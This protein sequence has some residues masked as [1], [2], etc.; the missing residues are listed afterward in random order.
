MEI[1]AAHIAQL[2]G[3]T[4]HGDPAT[5]IR[6]VNGIQE[7]AEG[8]L[9]FVRSP[10]YAALLSAS[11]ASAV[12]IAEPIEELSL[13]QLVTPQP[14]LAFAQ[15]LQQF[16]TDQT[17]HPEGIHPTAVVAE[18]ARLGKGVALD[19]HVVVAEGAVLGDRV[20]IYAGAYIGRNVNIG[21]ET[22]VY[23][24]AVIREECTIGARC[25]LH[26][27]CT[28][29]T[30]G[31]G[32][33]PLGGVWVKIPQVGRVVVGD[34]VEVG[35][36]TAIDRATFGETR[37]GQ[38]TKIDNLVQIGHNVRIGEHCVIAGMAG[39]AGSAVIGNN[40]RVGASAGINGHIDIGDGASIGA[41]AGVTHSVPAGATVSGFPAIDHN[42]QRR[43]LVAQQQAPGLARRV[44]A[45]ERRLQALEEETH[46]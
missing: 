18:S 42:L 24:R 39:I 38:G 13:T 9:T 35:S 15:V 2:T 1:S 27:H 41:R 8:E 16:K 12:L 14:D 43:V 23:P 36:H 44:R 40:V 32:F 30:D 11:R 28:I 26:A 22:I 4:V 46:D 17:R 25:V 31:F 20:V 7:A 10:R 33:A 3:A 5:L 29:G 37:V 6:G 45:L 19:A 21:P 34:D